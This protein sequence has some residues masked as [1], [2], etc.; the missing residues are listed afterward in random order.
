[1]SCPRTQRRKRHPFQKALLRCRL[2]PDWEGATLLMA[3]SLAIAAGQCPRRRRGTFLMYRHVCREMTAGT[4]QAGRC[5]AV[6]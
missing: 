1:M 5:S 4:Y 6:C 2:G 3:P